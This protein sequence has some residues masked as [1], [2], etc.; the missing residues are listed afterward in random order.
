MQI[1]LKRIYEEAAEGDGQ[2]ILVDRLWPRGLKK[3]KAKV[4]VWKKELAPSTELRQW[5]GHDVCKWDTFQE[6]YW[7]EL[8]ANP[9][10]PDFLAAY[11]EEAVLTLVYAA[12]DEKHNQAVVL[13][14]YL[15]E[16]VSENQSK[17]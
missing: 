12:K 16:A 13:K 5:F 10:L 4:A 2:R 8:E 3:E 1:R 9:V 14:R 11:A 17:L 15:E 6:R 7:A